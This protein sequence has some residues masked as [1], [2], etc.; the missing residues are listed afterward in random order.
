MGSLRSGAYC[1]SAGSVLHLIYEYLLDN[2]GGL[3]VPCGSNRPR[4]AKSR[5]AWAVRSHP[6]TR[7][8]GTLSRHPEHR[9][10]GSENI[11][12]VKDPGV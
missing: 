11:D 12:T 4:S 6:R 7:E 1:N 2:P 10:L 8:L 3:K 9:Q 5:W